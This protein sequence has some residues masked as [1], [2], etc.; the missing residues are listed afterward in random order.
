MEGE[1]E[2]AAST[3]EVFDIF[4]RTWPQNFFQASNVARLINQPMNGEET[5]AAILRAFFDSSGRRN[6]SDVS[7]MVIGKRLATLIDAPVFVGDR[8]MKLGRQQSDNQAVSRVT[9][10]FKVRVL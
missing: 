4:Y 6:S 2:D 10:S 9:A 5:D 7:S 3:A 8:T 1:D